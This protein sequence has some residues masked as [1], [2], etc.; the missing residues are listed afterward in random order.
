MKS[1]KN[2]RRRLWREQVR[3]TWESRECPKGKGPEIAPE[4]LFLNA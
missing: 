4:P 2:E 3:G 1:V